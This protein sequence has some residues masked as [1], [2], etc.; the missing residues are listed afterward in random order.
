M[1]FIVVECVNV[2]QSFWKKWKNKELT[3]VKKIKFLVV[4][5]TL[6]FKTIA[7]RLRTLRL[8]VV[9]LINKLVIN[10]TNIWKH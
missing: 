6:F 5:D 2:T 3:Y 10:F 8:Y 9:L 1:I 7:Q 4:V